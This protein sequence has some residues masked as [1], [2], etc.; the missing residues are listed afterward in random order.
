MRRGI[1]A[2]LRRTSPY[3]DQLHSI[4]QLKKKS[5]S[6]NAISQQGSSN[7]LI[8]SARTKSRESNR[9]EHAKSRRNSINAVQN[10]RIR[11]GSKSDFKQSM[12]RPIVSSSTQDT[13]E[14]I[15]ISSIDGK[16]TRNRKGLEGISEME[17]VLE[18]QVISQKRQPPIIILCLIYSFANTKRE[19]QKKKNLYQ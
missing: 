12:A 13:A 9:S 6:L 7:S 2:Q 15:E 1:I 19:P 8:A 10:L 17:K 16:S 14:Y 11:R 3:R 4:R 18:D 5:N